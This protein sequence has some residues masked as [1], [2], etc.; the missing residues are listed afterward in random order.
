MQNILIRLPNWLGD[1]IMAWPI[2]KGIQTTQPQAHIQLIG[3][4]AFASLIK[5]LDPNISFAALPKKNLAYYWHILRT[6]RG[7]YDTQII[8]T[9]SE[10][11]DIEALLINANNRIGVQQ[12]KKR[13][14]LTQP[15]ILPSKIKHSEQHQTHIWQ[16]MAQQAGL[17]DGINLHTNVP[18][19]KDNAP[20]GLICGS[21]NSPQ[22]RWPKDYWRA[23]IKHLLAQSNTNEF[24]LFGTPGDSQLC[25]QIAQDFDS[26]KVINRAGKTNLEEF[27]Q[28]MQA[29][30]L[31]IANDTGG[32]HLANALGIPVIALFA[33]TN[34][35]ST[36][37]IF[38]GAKIIQPANCPPTGGMQMQ[39][40]LV[41]QVL[42]AI[43]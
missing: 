30:R 32:M 18:L 7:Q 31:I 43:T 20:I 2:I 19:T 5:V 33:P 16:A 34:P 22:K 27:A 29:C 24:R 13:R 39:A 3:L 25:S 21:E 8:F 10:R 15:Y 11:G 40:L 36:A 23:L 26:K 17:I 35:V 37:P 38:A 42:A 12:G 1:I 41:E 14:I 28:E 9:N 6:Y 4:P